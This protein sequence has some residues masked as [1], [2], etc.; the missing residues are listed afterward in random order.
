MIS[1]NGLVWSMNCDSWL[2]PKNSLIA[3]ED[4]FRVDQ[5]VR[6]QVFAFG[7]TEAL[8]HCT[9]NA[10]KTAAEL[11]LG[12]LAYAANATVAEMVD[13]IHLTASVTQITDDLD[14]IEDIVG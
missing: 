5:V 3:A 11:V 2:E 9:L 1:D 10:G 12:Q 6:H 8:F 14:G 4:R 7:L 13:V